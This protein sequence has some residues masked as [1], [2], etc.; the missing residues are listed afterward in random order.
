M[1]LPHLASFKSPESIERGLVPGLVNVLCWLLLRVMCVGLPCTTW[2]GRWCGLCCSWEQ[3]SSLATCQVGVEGGRGEM[4]TCI[5]TCVQL[6]PHGLAC[7][8]AKHGRLFVSELLTCCTRVA[9]VTSVCFCL[10]T[11]VQHNFTLVVLG[12]VAVS[13]LPVVLEVGGGMRVC[14]LLCVRQLH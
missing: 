11:V 6:C 10:P 1:L 7:G 12:I 14:D 5:H 3:A 8:S 9:V 13:V 2:S 4:L